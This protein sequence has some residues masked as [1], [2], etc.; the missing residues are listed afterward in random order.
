MN[1]QLPRRS[2][3]WQD[4]FGVFTIGIS[5]VKDTVRY[6]NTQEEHHAKV[7]FAEEW[8]RI[9]DRHGIAEFSC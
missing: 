3:A 1:D 7:S 4:A 9:L 6:I 5:Q 8:R 2:F